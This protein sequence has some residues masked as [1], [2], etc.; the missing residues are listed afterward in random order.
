M[1]KDMKLQEYSYFVST[2]KINQGQI[3][4]CVKE[5]KHNPCLIKERAEN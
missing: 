2:F 5:K 1:N 4:L 3:I